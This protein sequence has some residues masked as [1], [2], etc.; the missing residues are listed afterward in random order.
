MATG[1]LTAEPLA[2]HISSLIG[3]R[4]LH[5]YDAAAPIVDASTVNMDIA[6]FASRYDKGDADYLN[7]P[8][9]EEQYNAFYD[10]L[11]TAEAAQLA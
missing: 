8:M 5:F 9:T 10:A 2:E 6:Y 11:I 4:Q 1:P 7:C 3:G